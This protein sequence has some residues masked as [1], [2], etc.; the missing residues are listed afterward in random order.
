MLACCEAA[1]KS[2]PGGAKASP[3]KKAPPP[4]EI[5]GEACGNELRWTCT[6]GPPSLHPFKY[7]FDARLEALKPQH[8][9]RN[10]NQCV[11]RA[12][13]KSGPLM[14]VNERGTL[15]KES[16]LPSPKLEVRRVGVLNVRG[17]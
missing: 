10:C 17:V 2:S 13:A 3:N 16:C 15:K 6:P 12:P 14:I 7:V 9:S 4:L 8:D 11:G 5:P 1:A